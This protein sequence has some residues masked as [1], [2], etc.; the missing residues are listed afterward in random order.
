M[1]ALLLVSLYRESASVV[2]TIVVVVV[3]VV[4]VVFVVQSKKYKMVAQKHF[5]REDVYNIVL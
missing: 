1:C 3:T 4:A 2:V 5:N